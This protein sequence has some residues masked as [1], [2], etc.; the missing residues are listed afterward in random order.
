MLANHAGTTNSFDSTELHFHVQLY[1]Y[2]LRIVVIITN[3]F[4]FVVI[5]HK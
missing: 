2:D 4:I 5:L 3:C 1:R